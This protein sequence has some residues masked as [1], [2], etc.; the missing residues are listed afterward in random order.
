MSSMNVAKGFGGVHHNKESSSFV[1]SDAIGVG[2]CMFDNEK[3]EVV[4]RSQSGQVTTTQWKNRYDS[5]LELQGNEI[6]PTQHFK[7][8]QSAAKYLDTYNSRPKKEKP[9]AH[10]LS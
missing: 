10:K 7:N 5:T 1:S 2:I 4:E 8:I 9:I 6:K 3:P